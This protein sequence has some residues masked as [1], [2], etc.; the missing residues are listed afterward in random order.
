MNSKTINLVIWTIL[1]AVL[2]LVGI[3]LLRE[4][5]VFTKDVL[6]T[7]ETG[8]GKLITSLLDSLS[9]LLPWN[10]FKSNA[11]TASTSTGG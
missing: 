1:I 2:G 9:R 3:L 6:N 8:P 7:L 5:D 11:P 10:W 4:T